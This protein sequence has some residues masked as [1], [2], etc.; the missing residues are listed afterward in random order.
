VL[1]KLSRKEDVSDQ[2]HVA[3]DCQKLGGKQRK[4]KTYIEPSKRMARRKIYSGLAI[5]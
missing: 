3:G 4:E 5:Q 2:R 1:G